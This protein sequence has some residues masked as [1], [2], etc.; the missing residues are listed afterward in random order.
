MNSLESR[1]ESPTGPFVLPHFAGA[2][3]PY[4]DTGSKGAILGL[5]EETTAADIYRACME[6][7]AYE[8][9]LN[10]EYLKDSG[11]HF[12]TFGRPEAV[13]TLWNGCK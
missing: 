6:G 4:M 8:M 7:V 13:R 5:T 2:A 11:I 9:L 1:S 12:Q 3:T 10:L